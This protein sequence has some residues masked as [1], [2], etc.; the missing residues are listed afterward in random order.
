MKNQK[1]TLCYL[2]TKINQ[3]LML[4]LQIQVNDVLKTP[5]IIKNKI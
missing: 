3:N 4:Q 5:D 1:Q 2:M